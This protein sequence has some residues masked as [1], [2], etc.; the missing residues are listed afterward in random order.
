MKHI[1]IKI[2]TPRITFKAHTEYDSIQEARADGWGFGF[3]HN[4]YMILTR[5][6]RVGAVVRGIYSG[7]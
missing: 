7:N 5:D 1:E 6:N 2:E 3:Q 4:E